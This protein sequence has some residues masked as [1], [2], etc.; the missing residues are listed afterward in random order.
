MNRPISG[1]GG[2]KAIFCDAGIGHNLP[3]E[4]IVRPNRG[5]DLAFVLDVSGDLNTKP[6]DELFKAMQNV[7]TFGRKLPVEFS[8]RKKF[9]EKVKQGI[10]ENN[11]PIIFGDPNKADEYCVVYIPTVQIK[12]SDHF[13]GTWR[14]YDP[15]KNDTFKLRWDPSEMLKMQTFGRKLAK[16]VAP[17]LREVILQRTQANLKL[18][19]Q[20]MEQ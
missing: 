19:S 3:M 12:T 14:Q 20:N 15:M 9:D 7:T 10:E 16:Y 6:G 17:K 13:L 8:N 11:L 2:E 18:K 4:A 5:C 1:R